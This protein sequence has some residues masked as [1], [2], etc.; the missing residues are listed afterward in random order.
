MVVLRNCIYRFVNENNEIIYI[1]KAKN[2]RQRLKRHRHLS[3]ECYKQV[4]YVEFIMFENED[5]MDFAERYF[6]PKLKPQFNTIWNSK[7]ITMNIPRLN[8]MK[9][10]KVGTDDEI[11][12]QLEEIK[13]NNVEEKIHKLENK[14]DS[15]NNKIRE[16]YYEFNNSDYRKELPWYVAFVNDKLTVVGKHD[17]KIKKNELVLKIER[18]AK[19]LSMWYDEVTHLEKYIHG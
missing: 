17:Y 1:G 13:Y 9:W 14:I 4:K 16:L 5:D 3:D 2:L 6:I 10:L 12:L 18:E 19:K 7:N 15:Q 11:K 8:K